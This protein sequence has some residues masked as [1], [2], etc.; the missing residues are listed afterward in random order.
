MDPPFITREVW[1][2]YARATRLLLL[3]RDETRPPRRILASTI[4]ENAALMAELF[5]AREQCFKLM[6]SNLVYQ[7]SLFATL[8]SARL[9][10]PN[11]QVDEDG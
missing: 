4:Q 10:L 3:L 1:E 8:E 5:G 9:A 2:L 6:V 7:F 11:P